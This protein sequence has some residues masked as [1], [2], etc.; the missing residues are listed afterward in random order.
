MRPPQEVYSLNPISSLAGVDAVYTPRVGDAT[1][2]I[3]PYVGTSQGT[4][5]TTGQQEFINPGLPPAQQFPPAK[6]EVESV[7]NGI[8]RLAVTTTNQDDVTVLS[9]YAE[10][11]VD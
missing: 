3:Q 8:V 6:T 4:G 9:G 2:L 7:E 5:F 1:L 11:R 10:A